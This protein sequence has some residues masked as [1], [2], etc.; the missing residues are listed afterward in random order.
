MAATCGRKAVRSA[1]VIFNELQRSRDA[2]V[3]PVV[4]CSHWRRLP[5]R[6]AG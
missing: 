5:V 3:L 1:M 4:A 6:P 2:A